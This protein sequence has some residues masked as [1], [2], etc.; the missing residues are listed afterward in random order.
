[1]ALV[2]GLTSFFVASVA[3]AITGFLAG[4]C[5]GTYLLCM[6]SEGLFPESYTG[7]V[8]FVSVFAAIGFV[9][10]HFKRHHTMIIATAFIG[11]YTLF[12]AISDIDG[13]S[14]HL[15]PIWLLVMTNSE[16]LYQM[17]VKDKLI[18]GFLG[19]IFVLAV[20]AQYYI[21]RWARGLELNNV[22]IENRSNGDAGIVHANSI[23]AM[24]PMTPLYLPDTPS[25]N[26]PDACQ[27]PPPMSH[28]VP[29]ISCD[30]M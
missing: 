22:R 15:A 28:D 16:D 2:G 29:F 19:V 5:F 10:I 20:V 18:V 8:A 6:K 25:L 4:L 11:T 24:V 7:R 26:N 3:Q 14:F 21:Y 13:A 12:Y 1:M 27:L 23:P 30:G 9:G 17:E